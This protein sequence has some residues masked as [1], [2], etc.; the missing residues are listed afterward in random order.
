M[1]KLSINDTQI[2]RSTKIQLTAALYEIHVLQRE[3]SIEITLFTSLLSFS[4]EVLSL[5]RLSSS[6]NLHISPS[7]TPSIGKAALIDN[8]SAVEQL[9]PV[10]A[11]T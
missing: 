8:L 3:P 7:G 9:R 11:D 5:R 6:P 4:S 2:I 1:E 10:V